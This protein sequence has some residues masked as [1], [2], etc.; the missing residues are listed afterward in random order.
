M[1]GGSDGTHKS[2]NGEFADFQ[3]VVGDDSDIP[4]LEDFE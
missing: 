4:T 3:V 1:L 2:F